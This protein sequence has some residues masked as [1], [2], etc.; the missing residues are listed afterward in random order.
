V[1]ITS[2]GSSARAQA[3]ESTPATQKS[4]TAPPQSSTNPPPS[5]A[6]TPRAPESQPWREAME[7][8]PPQSPESRPHE[9]I[10][11]GWQT[12]LVDGLGVGLIVLSSGADVVGFAVAALGTLTI[13]SP[14]VHFAHSN[15]QGAV[16][17]L[18]IRVASLG[19]SVLGVVLIADDVFND[20]SDGDSRAIVGGASLILSFAGE[21][22]AIT[23][24]ASLLA[25]VPKSRSSY[26][27]AAGIA[28][29][30]DPKRGSYGTILARD[31][32]TARASAC[33]TIS[34]RQ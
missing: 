23:I 21:I 18:G 17:S 16:I 13:G 14:I 33:T 25:F 34:R 32:G 1:V 27:P 4:W 15:T 31:A 5:A 11:Y 20:S 19:L 28:P 7:R 29:W 6:G 2:L 9:R 22:A 26:E 24:D 30:F 12:L 3:E 8:E 10:Y